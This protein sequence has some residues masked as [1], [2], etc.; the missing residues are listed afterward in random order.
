LAAGVLILQ[1][2]IIKKNISQ[3][4]IERT[5]QAAQPE[6]TT[7]LMGTKAMARPNIASGIDQNYPAARAAGRPPIPHDCMNQLYSLP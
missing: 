7:A 6:L 4:V 3:P 2:I 1:N 5:A